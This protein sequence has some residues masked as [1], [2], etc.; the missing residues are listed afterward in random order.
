MLG[1]EPHIQF[2][3][4]KKGR[5]MAEA[6]AFLK[7]HNIPLNP[8]A[9]VGS[10]PFAYRQMTEISK[11]LMGRVRMLVLDE[12]TSALTSDDAGQDWEAKSMLAVLEGEDQRHGRRTKTPLASR[13]EPDKPGD[14]LGVFDE[15]IVAAPG[16]DLSDDLLAIMGRHFREASTDDD[17][18]T[19]IKPT[20]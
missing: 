14:Q 9:T 16:D 13:C 4:L 17:A 19:L 20:V 15:G 8:R 7:A 6:E 18:G 1:R 5:L 10:L 12:P 3:F 11:A 2:G